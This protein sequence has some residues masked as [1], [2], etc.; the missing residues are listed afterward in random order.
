LIFPFL[1][2]VE[3]VDRRPL[4]GLIASGC[5]TAFKMLYTL[6]DNSSTHAGISTRMLKLCV[7]IRYGNHS[8]LLKSHVLTSHFLMLK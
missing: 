3:S 7:N 4:S 6:S 8:T 5:A 2:L 1:L